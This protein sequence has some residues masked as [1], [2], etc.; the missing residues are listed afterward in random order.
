VICLN[1]LN[2]RRNVIRSKVKCLE[3]VENDLLQ[4][5]KKTIRGKGR[6]TE[7]NEYLS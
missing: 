5:T 3:Y 6:I 2:Y 1:K 4:L 7:K